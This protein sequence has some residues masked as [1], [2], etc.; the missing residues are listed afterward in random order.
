MEGYR[1]EF[2]QFSDQLRMQNNFSNISIADSIW[3]NNNNQ[4]KKKITT[5]TN[6]VSDDKRF[7]SLP[8]AEA[9]PRDEA[10]DSYIFIC[11]NDIMEENLKEQLFDLPSK[12]RRTSRGRL[13]PK[14]A[15]GGGAELGK[16]VPMSWHANSVF[17]WYIGVD[18]VLVLLLPMAVVV[19][20]V[21]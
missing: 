21:M 16:A 11:N 15:R 20:V 12:Y 7:K 18:P 5:M 17:P 8:T 14:I 2:W 13:S 3:S 1:R 10:I 19:V 9:L 6:G 4:I